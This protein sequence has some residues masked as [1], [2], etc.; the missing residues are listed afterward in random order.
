MNFLKGTDLK[1]NNLENVK[2]LQI[3]DKID[4]NNSEL[5]FNGT[6]LGLGT[7]TPHFKI[8]I[9]GDLRIRTGNAINFHGTGASDTKAK[10]V[11]NNTTESIDFIFED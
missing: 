2:E 5:I 9:E 11:Y 1:N 6:N 10:I 3:N 8:D 7:E 4:I